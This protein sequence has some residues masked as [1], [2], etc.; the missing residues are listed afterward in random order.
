MLLDNKLLNCL[1]FC[2]VLISVRSQ[3]LF[4][5]GYSPLEGRF[6][7]MAR[8]RGGGR[9]GG[10][11]VS[12]GQYYIGSVGKSINTATFTMEVV[13]FLECPLSEV[14]LNVHIYVHNFVT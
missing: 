4:C 2:A 6:L 8:S 9:G 1:A 10:G 7:S 13:C 11:L 12:E 5:T 3:R 14:P